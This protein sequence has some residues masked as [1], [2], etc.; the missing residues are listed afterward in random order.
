MKKVLLLAFF[1]AAFGSSCAHDV[2]EVTAAHN[3]ARRDIV[4]DKR[5][6]PD[7]TLSNKLLFY[8]INEGLTESGFRK[9]NFELANDTNSVLAINYKCE[10]YDDNGFCLNPD[11]QWRTF[12]FS[13]RERKSLPVIATSPKAHDFRFKVI[14]TK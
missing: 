14:E 7:S 6:E 4:Q 13:G 8:G 1:A 11:A 3:Q 9:L 10:W 12:T 5:Y 2:N